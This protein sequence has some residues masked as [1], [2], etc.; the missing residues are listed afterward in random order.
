MNETTPVNLNTK[1][2]L[3]VWDAAPRRKMDP[4]YFAS[5]DMI[6]NSAD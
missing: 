6:E 4:L 3:F 5:R 1:E 2:G